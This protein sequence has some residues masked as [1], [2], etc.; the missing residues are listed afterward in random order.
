MNW[1]EFIETIFKLAEPYFAF[2][3]D[4]SHAQIAHQYCLLLLEKEGGDRRIVEPA[5][6]L[7]DVGWSKLNPEQIKKAF[8][9]RASGEEAKRLNRVH[10]IEG[11]VIAGRLLETLNYDPVVIA[12]ITGM[13]EHHDSGN[14]PASLEEKILKDSDRLWRYS[15]LGFW[16]ERERQG[17]P[18]RELYRHLE[19]RRLSWFFTETALSLSEKELANRAKEI[20]EQQI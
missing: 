16:K 6:I 2:R 18:P 17:L 19:N 7:H 3:D 9:V 1:S 20:A 8:G 14:D 15:P 4:L 5:V 11:A 10:E 12:Q 13:I